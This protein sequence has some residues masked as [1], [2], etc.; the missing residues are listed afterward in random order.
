MAYEHLKSSYKATLWVFALI[1]V[2]IFWSVVVIRDFS[3]L[4]AIFSA[5]RARDA[6]FAAFAP[7]IMLVLGGVL[8]S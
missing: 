2:A 3:D 5:I 1:N 8:T 7:I 6:S 4:G